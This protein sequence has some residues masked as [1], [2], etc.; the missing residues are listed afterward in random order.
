MPRCTSVHKFIPGGASQRRQGAPL[1]APGYRAA[2]LLT[3]LPSRTLPRDCLFT[4][5]TASLHSLS[6]L[7][8]E[9]MSFVGF[10]YNYT[11]GVLT[12]DAREQRATVRLKTIHDRALVHS[13]RTVTPDWSHTSGGGVR[14]L[15]PPIEDIHRGG[16]IQVLAVTFR[17]YSQ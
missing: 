3:Q 10:V 7:G 2:C 13:N 8:G 4:H 9:A 5:T 6:R 11:N 17:I 16:G 12:S 15:V 14:L 1:L